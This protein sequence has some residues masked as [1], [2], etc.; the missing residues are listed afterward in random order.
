MLLYYVCVSVSLY[1]SVGFMLFV[2]CMLLCVFMCVIICVCLVYY[3]SS[4][5]GPRAD[6][7]RKAS[8]H[9]FPSN[10]QGAEAPSLLASLVR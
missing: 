3:L 2:F 4:A 9:S 8:I 10:T 6:T 1:V 7:Y 5:F